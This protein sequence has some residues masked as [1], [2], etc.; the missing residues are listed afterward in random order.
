MGSLG[1]YGTISYLVDQRTGEIGLRMA[2]GARAGDVL[3]MVIRRGA[4]LACMGWAIGI[5][6]TLGLNQIP[7][8]L[9]F[10]VSP[11]DPLVCGGVSRI[12][13]SV[14]LLATY[15]PARRASRIDPIE[16]LRSE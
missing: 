15:L 5:L 2:L 11:T 13:L 16:A 9:R 10:D 4:G 7:Q 1:F 3:T 14:A 12:L 6:G 8:A